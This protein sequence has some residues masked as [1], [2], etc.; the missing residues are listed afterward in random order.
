MI[1]PRLSLEI[2]KLPPD[3]VRLRRGDEDGV[4]GVHEM[5]GKSNP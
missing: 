3:V 2:A 1:I 5:P 4:E